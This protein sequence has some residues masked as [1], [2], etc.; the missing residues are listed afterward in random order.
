MNSPIPYSISSLGD[1]A[2]T[3]DYGNIIDEKV[4]VR[5]HSIRDWLKCRPFDGLLDIVIGYS[6]LSVIFDPWL[7][8]HYQKPTGTI[9]NW[10]KALLIEADKAAETAEPETTR[11]VE[12]PVCYDQENAPDLLRMSY[13]KK[14]GVQEIIQTHFS[15]TYRVYMI[16]FLPGF[17]YLGQ[18]EERLATHRKDRPATVRA[19]S[20]G[21]AG[22]QTGIY[23]LNSPGG[24]NIIGR[25][26]FQLFNIKNDPPVLVQSGD[27]VKFYPIDLKT[28]NELNR[29]I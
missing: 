8:Y 11:V 9:F 20:V 6:S 22:Q 5:V 14:I 23:P 25:T 21:I 15:R 19:G 3:I 24:W 16:G 10:I 1:S 26:P 2:V 7:V 27:Y 17:A 28:F 12:I 13:E 4:S 18:V 29:N